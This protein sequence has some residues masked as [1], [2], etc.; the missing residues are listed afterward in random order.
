M[1]YS[2]KVTSKKTI[3]NWVKLRNKINSNPKEKKLW[4]KVYNDFLYDRIKIRYLDPIKAIEDT[5][6]EYQGE[7]FSIVT[8]QCSLIEFL[9]TTITGETYKF[10]NPDPKNFEYNQSKKKFINFLE[11]R[12]PFSRIFDHNLAKDVYENIRCGLLHEAQTK[13]NWLIRV[14]NESDLIE[15]RSDGMIVFDRD[16]FQKLLKKFFKKYK[17]DL[18]KDSNLQIALRRKINVICRLPITD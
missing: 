8:I 3:K 14:D 17:I 1:N 4:K 5:I 9:E 2:S 18:L 13:G 6:G 12:F 10:K 7:G 16:K 15:S 11:K